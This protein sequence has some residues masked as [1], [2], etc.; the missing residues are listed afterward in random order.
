MT[1]AMIALRHAVIFSR[2]DLRAD[3]PDFT[4]ACVVGRERRAVVVKFDALRVGDF[5]TVE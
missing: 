3:E 2:D 5:K 1:A 4:A